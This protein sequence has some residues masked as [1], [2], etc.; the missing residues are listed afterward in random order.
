MESHRVATLVKAL[1]AGHEIKTKNIRLRLDS[2]EGLL[3][4]SYVLYTDGRYTSI[5]S[6]A[7]GWSFDSV[8]DELGTV[9]DEE[10]HKA[11]CGLGMVV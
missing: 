8:L 3:I 4:K 6:P 9:N 2:K 7:V 10:Y 5:W 1:Y 11:T